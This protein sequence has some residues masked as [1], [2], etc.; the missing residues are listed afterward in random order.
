MEVQAPL[1]YLPSIHL[2]MSWGTADHVSIVFGIASPII[3]WLPALCS[4]MIRLFKTDD[5]SLQL[6]EELDKLLNQAEALRR[7]IQDN[8]IVVCAVIKTRDPQYL[9]KFTE[10]FDR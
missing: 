4:H 2:A 5:I 8:D 10:D 3:S 6:S 1:P 7:D 9:S